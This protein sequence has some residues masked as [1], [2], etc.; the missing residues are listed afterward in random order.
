MRWPRLPGRRLPPGRPRLSLS[1]RARVVTSVVLMSALGLATAGAVANTIQTARISDQI[2]SALAQEVEELRTLAEQ[3]VDPATGRSFSSVEQLV[4]VALQRNVPS[5]NEVFLAFQD[6]SL[7]AYTAGGL[8]ELATAPEIA[9]AVAR[10]PAGSRSVVNDEVMTDRGLVKLSMVPVGIEGD[11]AT[12][13]YVVAHSVEGELAAQED[14]MRTYALVALGA[15]VLVGGVGWVVAGRLLRPLRLLRDTTEQINRSDLTQRVEVSG[16]DDVSDLARTFNAMLDRL[17]V[18]FTTQREFLDDAGHELRTP[19]TV[20]RG[21]LELLDENDPADIAETRALLLDELDRMGRLVDDFILLAKAGRADFVRAERVHLDRLTDEVLDKA[22]A[23]GD[24]D[25]RVDARADAVVLADSQRLTQTLLQLADNAVKFS[26]PGATIGIGSAVGDD[27]SRLWVRDTGPGIAP[28]EVQGVFERFNRGSG[29]RRAE[30]SGLGLA[31]V[32][33]IAEAHDG[34]VELDSTLGQG[35]TFT[36]VLPRGHGP[37][38]DEDGLDG[39]EDVEG[40]DV[41]APGSTRPS[42]TTKATT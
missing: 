30:G 29:A 4:R 14:L 35:S 8:T 33:A 21:H 37:R 10:V 24:R 42:P 25:W 2:D 5:P 38:S 23:L 22:R 9:A 20:L 32:R 41:E 16:S 18:A 6:G 1:V 34:T 28:D 40:P 7:D 12:G 15:L 13:V 27:E 11:T 31:I 26:Q 36:I 3:G 17:E 19:I 39:S